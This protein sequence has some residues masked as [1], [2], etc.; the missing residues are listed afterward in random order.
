MVF[1]TR[2]NQVLD[3]IDLLDAPSADQVAVMIESLAAGNVSSHRYLEPERF[4]SCTLSGAAAR[5]AV[6][7]WIETSLGDFRKSIVLWFKDISIGKYDADLKKI[8]T[9]YTPLYALARCC[10]RQRMKSDGTYEYD[11]DDTAT[12][13]VA[14]A[15]WRAALKHASIPTWILTKALQRARYDMSAER[16]ALIKLILVRNITGGGSTIM[17]NGVQG[18]K[19]VAYVCGQIFAKLE[20]IQ[21]KALGDRNAGIRE[22]YFTYAMT[23]PAAAFGRLFNL[24]SKHMTKLKSEQPGVAINLDKDLQELCKVIDILNF[25]HQSSF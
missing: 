24:S 10:Q 21:Y 22:K 6:R 15:L 3:E 2:N 11:K 12:A 8:I 7:D 4:Y 25:P 1:W 23:T 9:S 13:R 5:I 18:V 19:P 14:V 20:H 16:A 17:E